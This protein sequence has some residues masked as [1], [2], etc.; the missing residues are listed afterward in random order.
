MNIG[1]DRHRD[2][3]IY[4]SFEDSMPYTPYIYKILHLL[5]FYWG[6]SAYWILIRLS[7]S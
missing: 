5:Y 7:Y 6:M 3:S 2:K 1:R 4:S